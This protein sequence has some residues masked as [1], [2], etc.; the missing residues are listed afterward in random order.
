MNSR[1][2]IARMTL[3][4]IVVWGAFVALGLVGVVRTGLTAGPVGGVFATAQ[5]IVEEGSIAVDGNTAMIGSLD[6]P[7]SGLAYVNNHFVA[8][9][10][11]GA[12]LLATPAAWFGIPLAGSL[13]HSDAAILLIGV[14]AVLLLLL[15]AAAL[16]WAGERL[17]VS[18]PLALLGGACGVGTMLF[19]VGALTNAVLVFAI[20]AFLLALTFA[21]GADNRVEEGWTPHGRLTLAG[22]LLA[23]VPFAVWYGW[24]TAGCVAVALVA[25][26]GRHWWRRVPWLA[27][28]GALPTA[29]FLIYN[30]V[31]FGR[32]WRGA[33]GYAIGDPWQRTVRGRFFETPMTNLRASFIALGALAARH[34]LLI[35][36]LIGL[37]VGLFFVPWR[38]RATTAI[39]FVTL[40]IPAFLDRQPSGMVAEEQPILILGAFGAIGSL[41]LVAVL[42]RDRPR[43]I[44]AVVLT[45][46]GAVGSGIVVS[47]VTKGGDRPAIVSVGSDASTYVA[48]IALCIGAVAL[49]LASGLRVPRIR[50]ERIVAISGVA[51]LLALSLSGCG[52]TTPVRDTIMSTAPNLLPPVATRLVSKAI[53]PLWTLDA[54]ARIAPD[55]TTLT[56]VNDVGSATSPRVPVQAGDGYRLSAHI[57]LA[58]G[59]TGTLV[60]RLLWTDAMF[61]PLA[62]SPITL[63][64]GLP[65]ATSAAPAGAAYVSVALA[66]PLGALVDTIHLQPLD[67]GRLDALPNYAKAA[68]AFSFDFETAMGGLIHT[69]GGLTDHD[70]ADAEARGMLMRNGANFLR[71][72][73]AAY[74]TRA[75][76]YVNGYNFLTGN[77]TRQQFVGNPTYTRYTAT[78]A[79]FASDYWV[80]H[81]WYSDDPYGTEQTNPAWYF[82]S[83]T[84]QLAED[85]HDIESHTF[86]HIFLHAGITAQQLDDDLTAWDTVAK[87]NGFAPAHSFA[88]P[89]R[90]SNSVTAEYYAV[91]VKHGITNV[92]RY[93]D[94]KLG[95]YDLQSVPVYP[96]IRVVPDQE[97]IDRAGDEASAQRG[98]DM[99]LATGGIFSL[100]AHPENIT[101]PAAQAIWGRVVAYA[102]DRRSLGLWVAPVTTITN[103]VDARA[104]LRVSSVR[105]GATT[106]LTL[107]DD[108]QA[109]VNDATLTLPGAPKQVAWTG[110]SGARDV[111]GAQI[112]VGNILPGETITIEARYS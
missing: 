32:P 48:P 13:H 65:S 64:V 70:V 106:V 38:A 91:L 58:P 4:R 22:L 69:R 5:R 24:I 111:N 72:L 31:W 18:P 9:A 98:I 41:L 45:A 56:A 43:W 27:L 92:T 12:A 108:G 68:L 55:G 76:F 85:G 23:C 39:L 33:W 1:T 21:D 53:N 46:I 101:S 103:F 60:A 62:A 73:F 82:G 90:A 37:A 83:M 51:I 77:T 61:R 30:T 17:G 71:Q 40:V 87:E 8:S 54:N 26:G 84:K 52:A 10:D 78:T 6:A 110:G 93:Y 15:A 105:I 28:G 96:Q 66:L 14:T 3:L 75:T 67:G 99:A 47:I 79:G 112:R 86:G 102:A 59:G 88:F 20:T 94:L 107:R 50:R 63:A 95:T 74:D 80:T 57:V 81:P 34:P 97:L 11:P 35:V 104:T 44:P 7:A 89:W 25:Q 42:A 100:W 49:L 36:G 109:G 16:V 2:S 29:L 19:P